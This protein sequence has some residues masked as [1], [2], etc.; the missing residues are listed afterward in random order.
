MAVS[1]PISTDVKDALCY[2]TQ[3]KSENVPSDSSSG[4]F[5]KK[6]IFYPVLLKGVKR[7][8]PTKCESFEVQKSIKAV[9]EIFKDQDLKQNIAG[10][11]FIATEVHYHET[12]KIGTCKRQ[13]GSQSNQILTY[14]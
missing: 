13:K 10:V 12:C 7:E 3:A 1:V 8:E 5:I 14:K 2:E 11:D 4:V 6:C 9:A